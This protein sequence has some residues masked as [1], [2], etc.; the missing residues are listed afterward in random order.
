M[1]GM[2]PAETALL[3]LLTLALSARSIP[4]YQSTEEFL[5]ESE[6][7]IKGDDIAKARKSAIEKA[8]DSVTE[9]ALRRVLPPETPFAEYRT[10][11]ETV[12]RARDRYVLRY[13]IE[14]E[15]A[16]GEIY[17]VSLKVLVSL[18]GIRDD[19]AESGSLAKGEEEETLLLDIM[20][21]SVH[22]YRLY[23]AIIENLSEEI[24][25]VKR[26]HERSM[27]AGSL[28]LE[29]EIA[30]GRT[31]FISR[32]KDVDF[33]EHVISIESDGPGTVEARMR[34]QLALG[35]P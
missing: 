22:S 26:V 2:K 5:G 15:L 21:H 20:I 33:V 27:S 32:L 29:V 24:P 12:N 14:Q 1:R 13:T 16:A 4:A 7:Q 30:C 31:T 25:G 9:Q 35:E 3:I 8:L 6:V 34:P 17:S 18:K 28:R 23:K 19:L 10:L 11:Q